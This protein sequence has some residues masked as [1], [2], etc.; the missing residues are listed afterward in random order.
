MNKNIKILFISDGPLSN[1]IIG[2]QGLPLL[3][4]LAFNG[5]KCHLLT[6]EDSEIHYSQDL[7]SKYHKSIKFIKVFIKKNIL[8]DWLNIIIK[9]LIVVFNLIQ[10]DD[11]RILHA[12]SFTP[13]LISLMV[14]KLFRGR[15]H[16]IYDNRGLFIEEQI[17]IGKWRKNGIKVKFARLLEFLILKNSA[18]IIVVSEAFRKYLSYNYR[19]QFDYK[20]SVIRN[21]TKIKCLKYNRSQIDNK[22]IGV[23][24]GSVAKW[25]N[26]SELENLIKIVSEHFGGIAFKI[27]TYND[28]F[29]TEANR[30]SLNTSNVEIY[31]LNPEEVNEMMQT[32]DFGI[33]LRD[34]IPINFVASPL[35]FSEYLASGLPVL[36]SEGIGDTEYIIDKYKVGVIIRGNN[37]IEAMN[38]VLKLLESSDIKERC[39][40]TAEKEF[41]IIDSFTEYFSIYKELNIE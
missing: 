40:L 9:G 27:F 26:I 2:S 35:K 19:K 25:Q 6:F 41:S 13:A 33:L 29:Q 22:I 16:F 37:Y 18:K 8:P 30:I 36:L 32:G 12:R 23:F 4:F 17:Y 21:R 34:K 28:S 1:P 10:S 3:E 39:L 24:S 7:E 5:Y 38:E 20:I 11:I 15:I 14:K 31:H